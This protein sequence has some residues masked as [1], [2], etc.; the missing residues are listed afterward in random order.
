MQGTMLWFDE[1][2]DYGFIRTEETERLCVHGA[3]FVGGDRPKGRC[4]GRAVDFGV[5]GEAENRRAEQV[6]FVP[7]VAPRRARRRHGHMR[8]S[9]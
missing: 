4:A 8:S 6:S 1:K 2:K 3:D 9:A 7:E 5:T